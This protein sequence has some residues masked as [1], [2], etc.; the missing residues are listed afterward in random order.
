MDH[1]LNVFL[2]GMARVNLVYR[3]VDRLV[4]EF[5]AKFFWEKWSIENAKDEVEEEV[6]STRRMCNLSDPWAGGREMMESLHLRLD[7]RPHSLT[8][9]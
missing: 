1:T 6:K 3:A 5:G 7:R 8:H 2:H 9:P 4:L